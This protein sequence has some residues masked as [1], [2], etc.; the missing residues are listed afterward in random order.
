[1]NSSFIDKMIA[2]YQLML[3]WQYITAVWRQVTYIPSF[4]VRVWP[5]RGWILTLTLT[6]TN[7]VPSR[8]STRPRITETCLKSKKT[9]KN[10][11]IESKSIKLDRHLQQNS[12]WYSILHVCWCFIY[13]PCEHSVESIC[14]VICRAGAKHSISLMLGVESHNSFI[15]YTD[16]VVQKYSLVHSDSHKYLKKMNYCPEIEI[17]LWNSYSNVK[18]SIFCE[19][20]NSKSVAALKPRPQCPIY[21]QSIHSKA[22]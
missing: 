6:P 20:R 18:L 1:M 7:G 4:L 14:R 13:F 16:C 21:R 22:R 9:K 2:K 19:I 11:Q 10:S 8:V 17:S 5:Y 15:S 3:C 12:F